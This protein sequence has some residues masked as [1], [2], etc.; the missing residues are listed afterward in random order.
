MTGEAAHAKTSLEQEYGI[1]MDRKA[2][3]FEAAEDA[4]AAATRQNVTVFYKPSRTV[5][6]LQPLRL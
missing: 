3:F 2:S 5:L 1:R 6:Q 4:R